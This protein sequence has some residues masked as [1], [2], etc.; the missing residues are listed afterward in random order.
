MAKLSRRSVLRAGVVAAA[1]AVPLAVSESGIAAV[2]GGSM[3]SGLRRATFRPHLR[4][5]FTFVG[6]GTSYQAKLVDVGDVKAAPRGHDARFRL[7]FRVT[8][9]RPAEGTYRV[10]HGR[11]A[12]TDLFLAPVGRSGDLYEA[13]VLAR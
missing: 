8:G 6:G 3:A 13:V 9:A 7:L 12:A 10:F 5:S 1:A 4:S 2:A 11:V